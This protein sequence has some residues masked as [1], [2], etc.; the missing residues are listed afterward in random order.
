M[1]TKKPRNWLEQTDWIVG[2][3]HLTYLVMQ[4]IDFIAGFGFGLEN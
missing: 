4:V 2:Y 3:C 1:K